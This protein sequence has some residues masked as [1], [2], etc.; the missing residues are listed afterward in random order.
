MN[1]EERIEVELTQKEIQEMIYCY[2][3]DMRLIKQLQQENQLLK[4]VF[5]EV[6]EWG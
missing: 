2:E 6:L 3:K 5:D 4:K 1:K